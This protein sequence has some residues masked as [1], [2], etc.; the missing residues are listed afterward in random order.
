MKK[1]GFEVVTKFKN[2]NINLPKRQTKAAAGYDIEC[3]QDFVVPSIWKSKV[4]QFI[5]LAQQSL[6]QKDDLKGEAQKELKPVLVPTGL[7]AYMQEDEVLMLVNRSSG[8]LKRG[9]V[10][11]N[12]MGIIDADYY[13]N[14][15]NEGEIFVQLTNYFPFDVHLKKGERIAQ[16][17]F[18]TYLK[19][20]DDD[21]GVTT[22]DGGFGSSGK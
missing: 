22:R 8:P 21:G 3:A 18:M 10:L 17:M 11:P 16:G 12:S 9:L 4:A 5:H 19:T 7:K 20:D 14:E 6:I 13:D 1:R 2:E 15:K